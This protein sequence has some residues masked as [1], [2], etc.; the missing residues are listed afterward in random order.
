MNRLT[1]LFADSRDR[2]HATVRSQ[3]SRKKSTTKNRALSARKNRKLQE[4]ANSRAEKQIQ[5]APESAKLTEAI[6]HQYIF[7]RKQ[8]E[9]RIS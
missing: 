4:N 7:Q 9:K 3:R 6:F 5:I 8:N 1:A 2:S